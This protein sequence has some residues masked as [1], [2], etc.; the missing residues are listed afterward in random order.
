LSGPRR[1][2]VVRNPVTG[3]FS[4]WMIVIVQAVSFFTNILV[5]IVKD[6]GDHASQHSNSNYVEHTVK[7]PF[8]IPSRVVDTF[9][10]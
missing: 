6:Y 3:L 7:T 1:F 9:P 4:L 2:F 10:A 8:S 5:Q